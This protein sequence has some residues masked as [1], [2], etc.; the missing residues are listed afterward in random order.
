ML[1]RNIQTKVTLRA[2]FVVESTRAVIEDALR[3]G[4]TTMA[5]WE[6]GGLGEIKLISYEP[7][8]CDKHSITFAVHCR[9]PLGLDGSTEEA[10]KESIMESMKDVCPTRS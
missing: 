3:G 5:D 7:V 4:S 8:A 10:A 1:N 9:R 6:A 2:K